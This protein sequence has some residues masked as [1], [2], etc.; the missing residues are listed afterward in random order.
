MHCDFAGVLSSDANVLDA[1]VAASRFAH[2]GGHFIPLNVGS[3][4]DSRVVLLDNLLLPH[5]LLLNLLVQGLRQFD[6]PLIVR[7]KGL[8]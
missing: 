5:A 8:A 6:S 4:G 1:V 3:R 2:G 7:D